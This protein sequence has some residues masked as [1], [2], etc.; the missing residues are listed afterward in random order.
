M[1]ALI[2]ATILAATV[3]HA[4]QTAPCL[5]LTKVKVDNHVLHQN[6]ATQIKLT[7]E[8]QHCYVFSGSIARPNEWPFI[9][10]E[11]VPGIAI[12]STHGL[13]AARLDQSSAGAGTFRAQELSASF[14]V[15]AFPG[16]EL[17]EHK[18]PGHI[19]YQVVDSQGNMSD[20]TLAFE[21]PLQ[22]KEP[23]R[24]SPTY[25]DRP[26]VG[27]AEKHPV[28]NKV[29]LP[30]VIIAFIP[31]FILAGLVSDWQC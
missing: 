29:L 15:I 3:A 9:D 30:L 13:D 17:G 28:W 21:F 23:Q 6:S 11:G 2:L 8:G 1:K 31:L 24:I 22:V 12:E 26:P 10:F 18:I 7:F 5:K 27:F 19:H 25:Y 20:E 16:L 4:Q 14:N